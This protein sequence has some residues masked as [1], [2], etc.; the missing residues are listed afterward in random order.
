MNTNTNMNMKLRAKNLLLITSSLSSTDL[1]GARSMRL[2]LQFNDTLRLAKDLG[3]E[4]IVVLGPAGDEILRACPQLEECDFVFDPNFEGSLFSSVQAGL[5]AS[6]GATFIFPFSATPAIVDRG[7][8]DALDRAS[9]DVR[10]DEAPD[11]LKFVTQ[12]DGDRLPGFPQL[13]TLNGLK[14][15]KSLPANTEW[16]SDPRIR[17]RV[18]RLSHSTSEQDR[19]SSD[20]NV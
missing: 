5:Q 2:T 19:T 9:W 20:G 3:L 12:P 17:I 11:V 6:T 13:V 7:L 1:R 8:W 15:L 16:E 14:R 4:P 18:I 10:P